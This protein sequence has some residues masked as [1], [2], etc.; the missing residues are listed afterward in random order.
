MHKKTKKEGNRVKAIN[1]NALRHDASVIYNVARRLGANHSTAKAFL[2]VIYNE[3]TPYS[4]HV[5]GDSFDYRTTQYAAGDND[6][7][8]LNYGYFSLE[9]LRPTTKAEKAAR[10]AAGEQ[11]IN[12]VEDPNMP[13]GKYKQWLTDNSL[14]DSPEAQIGY[15]FTQYRHKGKNGVMLKDLN[16]K[17]G[18]EVTKILMQRQRAGHKGAIKDALE[19]YDA[20]NKFKAIKDVYGETD[21]ERELGSYEPSFWD[22]VF[23]CGGKTRKYDTGGYIGFRDKFGDIQGSSYGIEKG[24]Q[25]QAVKEG[26]MTGLSTGLTTGLLG[27]QFIGTGAAT[28][29]TAGA[30]TAAAGGG[31]LLG[32]SLGTAIPVIGT[33]LGAIGGAIAGI[34]TGKRKRDR[35]KARAIEQDRQRKLIAANNR[36]LEDEMALDN[37]TFNSDSLSLQADSIDNINTPENPTY[38]SNTIQ[39]KSPFGNSPFNRFGGR[40]YKDG[41]TI[42]YTIKKGDTLW[43]IA[44]RF[45]GDGRNYA[46]MAEMLN[47]ADPSKIYVGDKLNISKDWITKVSQYRKDKPKTTKKTTNTVNKEDDKP[48]A[49]FDLEEAVVTAPKKSKQ[50]FPRSIEDNNEIDDSL[51]I[52]NADVST[53]PNRLNSSIRPQSNMLS[54]IFSDYSKLPKSSMKSYSIP[55]RIKGWNNNY[56]IDELPIDDSLSIQDTVISKPRTN[57]AKPNKSLEHMKILGKLNSMIQED[58]PIEYYESP[59]YNIDST[60]ME[61]VV[62]SKLGWILHKTGSLHDAKSIANYASKKDTIGVPFI[63]NKDGSIVRTKDLDKA[64]W[65]AGKSTG[66][67]KDSLNNHALGVEFIG[68]GGKEDLTDAQIRS[69][70]K[71]AVPIM[72][73]NNM[74]I[75]DILSHNEIRKKYIE[76][77]PEDKEAAK[78]G[79]IDMSDNDMKRVA[80]LLKELG[81]PEYKQS[82][83]PINT[84]SPYPFRCGGRTRKYDGGGQIQQV[85]SNA[86]IVNG[87]SHEQGGVQYSPQAE[88][89]GGEAILTDANSAYVFSDE[90]EYNGRTFADIAKPLMKHKGYLEEQLQ[91][92]GLLLGKALQMTDRSTYSIDRN[93]NSRNAEKLNMQMEETRV[94]VMQLQQMLNQLYNTQ[95]QMKAE[96]GGMAEPKTTFAFGGQFGLNYMPTNI[97]LGAT[98]TQMNPML[99]N[100]EEEQTETN[101]TSV[102]MSPVM[103]CGGRTRKYAGG[104]FAPYAGLAV[105]AGGNLIAGLMQHFGNKASI[106]A[107]DKLANSNLFDTPHIP[108]TNLEWDVNTD[109]T[110]GNILKETRGYERFVRDNTS[111]SQVARQAVLNA[112]IKGATARAGV[113]Q[114]EHNTEL[115]TRN[116]IRQINNEI[117]TKNRMI[118]M[119]NANRRYQ[120]MIDSIVARSQNMSG[121]AS[122]LTQLGRAVGT[123]YQ[124]KFDLDNIQ[125]T[126]L[127]SLLGNDKSRDYIMNALGAAGMS[128]YFGK[129]GLSAFNTRTAKTT[130]PAVTTP[131]APVVQSVYVPRTMRMKGI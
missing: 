5:V 68:I 93:T 101:E 84:L 115:A 103:R 33:V 40:I 42:D 130:T 53:R 113:K 92:Q 65:H 72:L 46:R 17:S 29:G 120:N 57:K 73:E 54:G 111:N 90:L 32:M 89:E 11:Y 85:A 71:I 21:I 3:T 91:M 9:N 22:S 122:T 15:M 27:S 80:A 28:A 13:L 50:F 49:H 35:A 123:G 117:N 58:Y 12:Y 63:I 95:E 26:A 30:T 82:N 20:L 128:K 61:P 44:K 127:I 99:S 62:N 118:D 86:Q 7:R 83:M 112:R 69:W 114:N 18:R 79:K 4:K 125:M 31:T 56:D 102:P 98:N 116:Q 8:V 52:E 121:L 78:H 55:K 25:G 38:M 97:G 59:N 110:L 94:Q 64:Y 105:E 76:T 126:N 51:E 81:V 14:I 87:P 100:E 108:S 96:Q 45:T 2:P 19:N 1:S 34:F 23:A 48:V 106:N 75:S 47:I 104:G 74:T 41:G 16:K 70:A 36:I 107:M 109:A 67:G 124:T 77:H 39:S 131:V 60:T 88:V 66:W 119:E 129:A 10:R 43:N 6:D 37:K 24:I